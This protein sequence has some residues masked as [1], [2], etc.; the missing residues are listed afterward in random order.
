MEFSA[1]QIAMMLQGELKGDA[2]K[3][4]SNVA[5]LETAKEGDLCF[6][7]DSKYLPYLAQTK[8]SVVLVTQSLLDE[9]PEQHTATLIL[10]E[11]A[12]AAMAQLLGLVAK[13]LNPARQ[14]IEQ[15]S[16]ISEGVQVPEDAY[17]GAFA[18]IGKNWFCNC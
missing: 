11:N 1:G 15:P 14:G 5:G 18:Y 10:V 9:E 4:V 6:L 13:T 7:C 16:F 2:E 17:I 12:R 8:A 3:K